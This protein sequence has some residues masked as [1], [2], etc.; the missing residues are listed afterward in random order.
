MPAY[1]LYF[2]DNAGHFHNVVELQADDDA[3]AAELAEQR[4]DGRDMELWD[5]SRFVRSFRKLEG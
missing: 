5:R 4:R 1:R 3:K 2:L